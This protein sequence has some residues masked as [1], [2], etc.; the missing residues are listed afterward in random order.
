[1][2]KALR[3]RACERAPSPEELIQRARGLIPALRAMGRSHDDQGRVSDAAIGLLRQAEF[4]RIV[5][6]PA[7]GGFGMHPRVLW[8]VAREV[9]R[10]DT[11]TGWILCLA[12]VH[13]WLL[14]MFDPRAQDEVF[15][16]GR[17]A[18]VPVLS[19]GVARDVQVQ[20][21][22][23]GYQVTGRWLYASGV[24][25]AD[26]MCV[27]IPAPARGADAAEQRLALVP[28]TAFGINQQSWRVA[29]MRGTG[30]KDVSLESCEIPL[31][32]TIS[33]ADAQ[34]GIFPGSSRNHGPMYRMPLNAIFALSTAAGVV[35]G[36]YGLLD[37]VIE[38]GR[39][40]IANANR[41][42]QH[43]DRYNQLELGQCAS[44]VHMAYRL[45]I[46]DIDEMHEQAEA[47]KP[48]STEQR[49]RYRADA[50]IAA[51]TAV[52]AADRMVSA[53]GGAILPQGPLERAFRDV[54]GM[55]S[56]FLLQPE[57]GG[58]LYG[59][60]LYGLDLPAHTRL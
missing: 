54:R 27:M 13:P 38:V 45:L 41:A 4:F 46:S 59:R 9:T 26:W 56:H 48:F 35:G 19:G 20:C 28:R 14:G 12:G 11:A 6:P 3:Q 58:E 1:M 15:T 18:V 57:I 50:A 23:S 7:C 55:A 47:H 22:A 43:E 51:R 49:A 39:K 53:C 44:M 16:E 40:R 25:V 32:R 2:N 8:A 60:T 36:A 37:A 29:S 30:S 33:W 17:Q 10:A 31:Y 52:T 21:T 34:L 5:Q 42:A 24:E